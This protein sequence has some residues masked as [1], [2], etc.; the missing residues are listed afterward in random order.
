MESLQSKENPKTEVGTRDWDIAAI[1]LT[2]C[3]F[4]GICLFEDCKIV[5]N[6]RNIYIPKIRIS[7][8]LSQKRK[9]NQMKDKLILNSCLPPWIEEA[10]WFRQNRTKRKH[11]RK[12]AQTL[13]FYLKKWRMVFWYF[14]ETPQLD[15]VNPRERDILFCC[16][17]CSTVRFMLYIY[18]YI[19]VYIY[20]SYI[21]IYLYNI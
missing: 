17:F 15:C 1:G 12:V 20:N 4:R 21:C 5:C 16:P 9:I 7:R 18:I 10:A 19:C 13:S 6:R 14:S 8:I 11:R 2:M 3:Y